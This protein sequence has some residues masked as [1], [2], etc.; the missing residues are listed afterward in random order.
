M[1]VKMLEQR[2]KG[3][4]MNLGLPLPNKRAM[5]AVEMESPDEELEMEFEP[6]PRQYI[7]V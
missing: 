4:Y 5:E 1:M 2:Q 3:H 7:C 6:R